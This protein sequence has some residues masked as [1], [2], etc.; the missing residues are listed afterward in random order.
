[1]NRYVP[2]LVDARLAAML[3]GQAAV[4]VVGPRACG[5]TTTASRIATSIA[6]L[7]RPAEAQSFRDDPDQG[8]YPLNLT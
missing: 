4:M 7:D 1:M 3:N 5:K 6:R 8:I 2:R